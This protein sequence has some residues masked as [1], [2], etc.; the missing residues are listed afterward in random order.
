VICVGGVVG[1]VGPGVFTD[2]AVALQ[3]LGRAVA[4]DLGQPDGQVEGAGGEEGS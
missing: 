1:P 3:V 4:E 2:A